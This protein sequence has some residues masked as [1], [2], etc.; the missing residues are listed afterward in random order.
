[1]TTIPTLINTIEI[2]LVVLFSLSVLTAV[3]GLTGPVG[4]RRSIL[5]PVGTV[6]SI[7]FVIILTVATVQFDGAHVHNVAASQK[8]AAAVAVYAN[9]M[10]TPTST[11]QANDVM[12]VASNDVATHDNVKITYSRFSAYHYN[13]VSS[14]SVGTNVSSVCVSFDVASHTWSSS[15]TNCQNTRS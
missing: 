4:A 12:T 1:M 11:T 3:V 9:T 15:L 8:E 2:G 14:S 13:V 10:N 7:V 6:T 5:A